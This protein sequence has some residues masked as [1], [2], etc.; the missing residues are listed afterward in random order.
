MF[1]RLLGTGS[2]DGWPNPF[3]SCNSCAA[4]AQAGHVRGQTSAL[5]DDRLLLDCGADAP[6]AA[7]R[8]GSSLAEVTHVLL[9][10]AHPDHC[11]PAFLLYR[12]WVAGSAGELTVLGP[13]PVID[14]CRGWL[15]PDSPVRLL[16]LQ[17]GEQVDCAGYLV[18][19][20]PATHL[21][22]GEALLYDVTGPTGA[23]LLYATD[24]GPLGVEALHVVAGAA[25]DLVLL[26]ETFGD[27]PPTGGHLDLA[28]FAATLQDLRRVGAVGEGTDVVAVHLSHA[29]PAGAELGERLAACGA[30]V[31]DDGTVL[32]VPR[33]E[34]GDRP[35]SPT[36]T[37]V[38]GGA[39]SGKS[40]HAEAA[41]RGLPDVVYVATATAMSSDPEWQRRV[42]EHRARRPAGWRTV[43]T[44][45]LEPLLGE[46]GGPLLIDC[47]TLWLTAVMDA[48]D[49]WT[50][51]GWEQG[52]EAAVENRID[53]L[54]QAWRTT[55]RTVV[56]VSNE[57]GSG[58]VPDTVSGRRFRDALGRLN[59]AVADGSDRVL[60]CVAGRTLELDR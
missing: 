24:T 51:T 37:L 13:P 14:A 16:P 12:S 5:V 29:N 26:E 18:G 2:A 7:V 44:T 32:S 41:L 34:S 48:C 60:L 19:A 38:L 50:D 54:A 9:T 36:R 28:S 42:A 1:V 56:A 22:P 52:A 4:A 23:R 45:A 46:P 8:A 30:R 33:I 25:Y 43:E 57:V 3:C 21:A 39:R 27:G 58:V 55:P 15:A 11:D 6:R 35:S 10:H 47:L 59:A 20:V 31:V 40:R 17:P 49:A 53:A